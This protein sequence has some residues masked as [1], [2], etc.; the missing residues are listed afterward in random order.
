LFNIGNKKLYLITT[1]ELGRY[2][3]DVQGAPNTQYKVATAATL[4]GS[5]LQP[6]TI[7]G[8]TESKGNQ[9][10][11][12]MLEQDQLQLQVIKPFPIL[13]IIILVVIGVLGG[14]AAA[15]FLTGEKR[16][17]GKVSAGR[18]SPKAKAIA[19]AKIKEDSTV[20]K[21]KEKSTAKKT[22]KK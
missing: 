2:L 15:Y 3:L 6:V 14:L 11:R 7:N 18:K 12:F 5:Y 13:L 8:V 16:R 9:R 22:K 4:N 21:I 1:P 10:L 20:T 19:R 17:W